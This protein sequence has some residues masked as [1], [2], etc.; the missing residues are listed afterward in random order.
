LTRES[1]VFAIPKAATVVHVEENAA[2][3]ALALDES[4][5]AEIDAAFPRGRP[6]PLATL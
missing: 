2:A 5:L 3:G 1:D 4:D 6:G